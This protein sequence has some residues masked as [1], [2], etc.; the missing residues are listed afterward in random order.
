MNTK[1]TIKYKL[2]EPILYAKDGQEISS[3]KVQMIYPS[4]ANIENSRAIKQAFLRGLRS[5][6]SD[7]QGQDEQNTEGEKTEKTTMSGGDVLNMVY[8]SDGNINVCISEFRKVIL[9]GGG[10]MEDGTP[11]TKIMYDQIPPDDEEYMLG[12]YMSDFLLAS[13]FTQQKE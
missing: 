1:K 6:S 9:N 10:T 4:K 7:R 3:N 2:S 8:M 11:I 12:E 5:M 13:W